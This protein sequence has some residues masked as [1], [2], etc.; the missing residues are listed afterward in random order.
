MKAASLSLILIAAAVAAVSPDAASAQAPDFTWNGTIEQG[1]AIEI[2]GVNG[3][4][5]A[6][7]SDDGR[8]H[9]TATRHARRSN[10][11]SVR[12]EV[13][14]HAGGVT[15]C[16]VYP[17]PEN[18]DRDNEC[19]PGGRG[20]MS[21]NNNDTRVD[22]VVRV[23]AGVRFDGGTVNGD[24]SIVGLRSNVE[25]S[26][27]NG[28]IEVQ[29]TGLASATTVNGDIDVRM[30]STLSED[31]DFTTVNGSIDIAMP[32]GLNA[33]LDATTGER[34]RELRL[35]RDR[36]RLDGSPPAERHHRLG[37]LRDR[38]DDRERRH[39]AAPAV[40]A[41]LPASASRERRAGPPSGGPARFLFRWR[42][43]RI[44]PT[45]DVMPISLRTTLRAAG[46]VAAFAAL[47]LSPGAAQQ[48]PSAT[49][50]RDAWGMPHV[51]SD[52]DAASCTAWRGR[53]P[54]TTG[55]SSRRTT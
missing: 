21:V 19:R 6:S 1:D 36:A 49:I 33:R 26:T 44:P 52:T 3:S 43:A 12:I 14:E 20:Q 37:R 50:H 40:V 16:A 48:A 42:R 23:P 34:H 53:S 4:V 9:V 30:G 15:I 46:V 18:A 17:T 11:E 41:R 54:R 7:L 8:V 27:V 51:F 32:A 29:T 35:R 13:I 5:D 39:P 2:A 25:V 45:F 31:V 38:S 10:P 22:F 47:P 28:G 55:R 24:V